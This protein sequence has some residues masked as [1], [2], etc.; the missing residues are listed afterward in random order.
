MITKI[1][2]LIKRITNKASSFV[3]SCCVKNKGNLRVYGRITIENPKNLTLGKNVTINEGA[4]I[5]CRDKVYIGDNVSISAGCK[6]LTTG[7]DSNREH[8]KASVFINDN[9]WLGVNSVILP[10]VQLAN[11]CIVGASAVVTKSEAQ[12]K[13]ILIGI[14]AKGYKKVVDI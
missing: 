6:I 1:F 7:L 2:N 10:G 14:P 8:T 3:V 5:N 4:Y 9:C 11:S 12:E 13:S